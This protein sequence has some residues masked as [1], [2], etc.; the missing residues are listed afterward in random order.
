MISYR[1]VPSLSDDEI[2]D[3]LKGSVFYVERPDNVLLVRNTAKILLEDESKKRRLDL[4]E[5]DQA[6]TA[7]IYRECVDY[8]ILN[9]FFCPLICL[10]PGNTLAIYDVTIGVPYSSDINSILKWIKE[11]QNYKLWNDYK[12]DNPFIHIFQTT[13]DVCTNLNM[14]PPLFLLKNDLAA[15]GMMDFSSDSIF[16]KRSQSFAYKNRNTW[17]ITHELRHKWQLKYNVYDFSNYYLP[18]EPDLDIRTGIIG[19][20]KIT[21]YQLQP[22]E[23][24]ANAYAYAYLKLHGG[25]D[26]DVLKYEKSLVSKPEVWNKILSR[27]KEIEKTL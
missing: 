1:E 2:L 18:G 11:N 7:K 19:E 17:I 10:Y 5:F 12:K 6:D 15:K 14:N 16:L 26:D 4:I 21:A 27:A 9:Q 24:D 13:L 25:I 22:C 8:C 3:Y 20:D 23:I